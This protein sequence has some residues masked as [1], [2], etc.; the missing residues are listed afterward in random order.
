[1]K[2]MESGQKNF[3]NLKEIFDS[4][5]QVNLNKNSNQEIDGK[6]SKY[7]LQKKEMKSR[8]E[9]LELENQSLKNTIEKL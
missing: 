6:L 3:N 2:M 5:F 4:L 9:T 7:K 8:I 1:M